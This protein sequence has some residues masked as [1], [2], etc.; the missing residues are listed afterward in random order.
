MSE[1]T[2]I[3][4]DHEAL[5]DEHTWDTVQEILDRHTKVKPCTSGYENKF[6]G[7]LKCADCGS[8]LMVH[9]DGRNKEKPVIERTFYQ[10][11]IYRVRGTGFC[12][13]HRINADDL[14]KLVLA[15]IQ[16]H[17]KKVIKNREKFM[18]K[19]LGRWI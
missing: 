12:S 5:V 11:R 13:Q 2:I 1:R 10:C 4:S 17:A 18:R 16:T 6:R 19:V 14:E 9:T 3:P 7:I 8:T 15:D